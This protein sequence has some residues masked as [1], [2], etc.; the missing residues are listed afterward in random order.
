[1]DITES[2]K[3]TLA[4]DASSRRRRVGDTLNSILTSSFSQAGSLRHYGRSHH[5]LTNSKAS[6]PLSDPPARPFLFVCFCIASVRMA[7]GSS[8]FK[9]IVLD[10]D[11]DEILAPFTL[12]SSSK[13]RA[14]PSASSSSVHSVNRQHRAS[15]RHSSVKTEGTSAQ[16]K[17]LV[18]KNE[19]VNKLGPV[20][21]KQPTQPFK[22]EPKSNTRNVPS[23]STVHPKRD[24]ADRPENSSSAELGTP[25][26]NTAT[27]PHHPT[28]KYRS[29]S[30]SPQS[31]QT[32]SQPS[33]SRLHFASIK[34][35]VEQNVSDHLHQPS[36]ANP[37]NQPAETD[38]RAEADESDASAGS[39]SSY[40]SAHPFDSDTN[41]AEGGVT[42]ATHTPT[43]PAQPVA[44]SSKLQLPAVLP[45]P[46]ADPQAEEAPQQP[47]LLWHLPSLHPDHPPGAQSSAVHPDVKR[48]AAALFHRLCENASRVVFPPIQPVIQPDGRAQ[49]P[50]L[51]T[52]AHA[53]GAYEM[54]MMRPA[55]ILP[56]NLDYALSP[57]YILATL[58]SLAAYITNGHAMFRHPNDVRHEV[59]L[60]R[61]IDA[62]Y[63][64]LTR[65]T[66]Q[67]VVSLLAG[68]E[69]A[70]KDNEPH[71]PA[72]GA[73]QMAAQLVD[74][75]AGQDVASLAHMLSSDKIAVAEMAN[76]QP[77][78]DEALRDL[79]KA[80]LKTPLKSHQSSGLKFLVDA[81]HRKL[82]QVPEDG[83]VCLW[84]VRRTAQGKRLHSRS[85]SQW[86]YNIP[87][88][89]PRGAILAD[90][91]GLGKTLTILSLILTPRDGGNI[92]DPKLK[93]IQDIPALSPSDGNSASPSS[94][95][96]R[97]APNEPAQ[98]HQ[99]PTKT[100]RA[101]YFADSDEDDTDVIW[102]SDEELSKVP[103]RATS[104]D[105]CNSSRPAFPTLICCPV[106]LIS[107][108]TEQ[109][110]FHTANPKMR[111]AV[112]YGKDAQTLQ[113]KR[114]WNC[115]DF[116]VTSYDWIKNAYKDIGLF[117]Q[118][119]QNVKR[120][121]E[122]ILDL[123]AQVENVRQDVT[124]ELGG[125]RMEHR[126]HKL[127]RMIKELEE[128][129]NETKAQFVMCPRRNAQRLQEQ[130]S[131]CY[132]RAEQLP[133][134]TPDVFENYTEA[135][136]FFIWTGQKKAPSMEWRRI[137]DQPWLR[138]VLDEAHVI[139]S[140][141]TQVH[142]AIKALRAERKIA[143]TGTPII[144]STLDFGALVSFIGVQPYNLD[145]GSSL[146]KS[147]VEG[148][149]KYRCSQ[150]VGI[151][152]SLTKSLVI[153]RTKEM[154]VN[155][156]P[157][158]ELPP[159]TLNRYEVE[160]RPAD[161]EYYEECEAKLRQMVLRWAED[162]EMGGKQSCILVFLQR[163]RQLANDRRLVP[164]DLVA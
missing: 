61:E 49:A 106:S 20:T 25:G 142:E 101:K 53:W 116:V 131:E 139:R 99:R 42:L 51:T 64:N 35:E 151:M 22:V 57:S 31:K 158:V 146:W 19:H 45:P 93:P 71:N 6:C 78:S 138:I 112:L 109:A 115:Y 79:G 155:G 21:P 121:A 107:N 122:K 102:S 143:V 10:S 134:R 82:P 145:V 94:R 140:F 7:Q 104:A 159:I 160:M 55:Q 148:G 34:P 152:R 95:K 56:A 108:W 164:S 91:M 12:R 38:P 52:Q 141:K 11:D 127:A 63:Q 81:E 37:V 76:L 69:M 132:A 119:K 113:R 154:K 16:R 15:T 58:Q 111:Y 44:S 41:V 83:E 43:D 120:H 48:W 18:S 70:V 129:E 86:Q 149:F 66:Q 60:A 8:P 27:A 118:C 46:P 85:E 110:D 29:P 103:S 72:F 67:Y 77:C 26:P 161:M 73:P 59:H 23:S 80:G 50:E 68:A 150:A 14:V 75:V 54:A 125:G 28:S 39:E 32:V 2:H 90:A 1:M 30:P 136:L 100:A 137:F 33:S 128:L 87:A 84:S 135:E 62:V 89:V 157:L 92:V 5:K 17:P 156:A 97:A 36:A 98:K 105:G 124:P 74:T 130:Y 24:I 117:E 13:E 126:R 47:L 88:F 123:R 3:H 96:K 133:P 147:D 9:P 4:R 144:N 163:M 65:Q 153:L 40:H 162:N 114:D